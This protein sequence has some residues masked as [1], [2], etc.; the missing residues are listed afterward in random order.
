MKNGKGSFFRLLAF[1]AGALMLSM[2][3]ITSASDDGRKETEGRDGIDFPVQDVSEQQEKVSSDAEILQTMRFTRCG[4]SVTRRIRVP[5]EWAGKSFSDFAAHYDVWQIEEF[6]PSAVEMSREVPLYCPAHL[7]LTVN[8]AGEV[9]LSRNEYGDGMA[10]KKTYEK[11]LD[12]FSEERKEKLILG[13]GFDSESEAEEW[14][15]ES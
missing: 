1:L 2:L 13:I 8:D 15:G 10:M 12:D 5:D 6:T 7:V 9:V 14:L 11:T 3:F 4:H